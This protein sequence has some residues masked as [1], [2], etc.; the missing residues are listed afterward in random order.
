MISTND[1]YGTFIHR[2]NIIDCVTDGLQ[3]G[4]YVIGLE[5]N[6]RTIFRKTIEPD[7]MNVLLGITNRFPTVF[8][9]K[10]P[11]LYNLCGSTRFLAWNGNINQDEK[12][13]LILTCIEKELE[14]MIQLNSFVYLTPG[15]YID[16]EQGIA[17][18]IKSLEHINYP[19]RSILLLENNLKEPNAIGATI[20]ELYLIYNGCIEDTQRH[21][22]II[23]NIEHFKVDKI[24]GID[25][26]FKEYDYY[27]P[28]NPVGV[29]VSSLDE[30]S[31]KH[32]IGI[33]Q[34][35]E[36]YMLYKNKNNPL[37]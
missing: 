10:L 11:P 34:R 26:L 2:H 3:M 13:D 28:F 8:F 31:L 14:Q 30:E 9:S 27:F 17:S 25:R 4:L 6:Q 36:M 29:I 24:V 16:T 19:D 20:H 1:K 15:K 7:E 21:L 12:T 33:C 37:N 18:I 23:L 32:L 5:F 35:R 22:G